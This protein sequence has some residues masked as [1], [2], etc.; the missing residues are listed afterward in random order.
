MWAV[1]ILL[2][3][4]ALRHRSRL[5][6]GPVLTVLAS[7]T[8]LAVVLRL[9]LSPFRIALGSAGN[10]AAWSEKLNW[11]PVLTTDPAG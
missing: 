7:W 6:L 2:S 1:G 3:L 11:I 5:T 10:Q 4:I 8:Y 9:T